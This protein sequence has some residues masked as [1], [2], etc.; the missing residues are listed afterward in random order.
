MPGGLRFLREHA[1]RCGKQYAQPDVDEV[2]I[3]KAEYNLAVEN[4]TFIQ[5]AVDHVEQARIGR[6]EQASHRATIGEGVVCHD[7]QSSD[8][9]LYGGHG[10]VRLTG[11]PSR[12]N[13]AA[14]AVS[15]C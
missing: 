13:P 12:S 15:V 5:E 10:P 2:D 7:D 8:A 11:Q 3:R 1:V 9:K 6:L 14:A 4:D